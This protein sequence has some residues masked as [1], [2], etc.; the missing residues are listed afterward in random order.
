MTHAH[1]GPTV[2]AMLV[3]SGCASRWEVQNAPPSDV[4]EFSEGSDYLVT[5]ASGRQVELRGV[6]VERD[7]LIGEVKDDPSGPALHAR[8]AIP[9][10]DVK[11]IAIRKPDGVATTFWVT[12]VGVCA[13]VIAIGALFAAA[14]ET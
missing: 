5:Q 12:T 1:L 11:A 7:S 13:L 8:L 3:L 6:S 14:N 2:V 9:L 4:V 10:A